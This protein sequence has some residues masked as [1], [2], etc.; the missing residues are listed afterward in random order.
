MNSNELSDLATEA[1]LVAEVLS[2]AENAED[3]TVVRGL[4][5]VAASIAGL[6]AAAYEI[7]AALKEKS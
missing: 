5:L 3:E 6:M 4:Y 1:T 7:A 2:D